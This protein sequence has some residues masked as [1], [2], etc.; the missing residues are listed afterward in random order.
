MKVLIKGLAFASLLLCFT[1][2]QATNFPA[3]DGN[4]LLK[5]S[6]IDENILL[7]QVANLQQEATKVSLR[8][9][10]GNVYY[11]Y[12][13]KDHNGYAMK[14]N[15]ESI[16]EGRYILSIHQKDESKSQIIYKTEDQILLSQVSN[17]G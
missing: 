5:V 13:I 2:A 15:I 6:Q 11:T 4:I 1:Q 17:R 12:R 7:L 14:V 8:D 3:S 9:L 16:P 10:A